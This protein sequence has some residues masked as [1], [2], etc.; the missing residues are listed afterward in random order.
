MGSMNRRTPTSRVSHLG[1]TLIELMVA[2]AIGAF[3]MIGAVTVFQ[4]SRTTFRVNDNVSRLQENARFALDTVVSDIRMAHYWGLTARSVNVTGRAK[5]TD[6]AGLGPAT[7]GQNWTINLESAVGATNNS[8]GWGC[9]GAAPVETNSDTLVVRR[10]SEES[11]LPAALTANTLYIQSNRQGGQI[12]AG[13]AIPATYTAAT[14][15]THRLIADGYYVSRTSSLSS[16]ANV[17][18]SLRRKTLIGGGTIQDQEIMT[19]IEDLQI[20][21]GVDTDLPGTANRGAVDRFVNAN[22]PILNPANAAYLPYAEVL[23]VRVWLRLRAE[24]TENGFVDTAA[25][26]YADQN[27]PAFNDGFRRIVVSKTI[28]IRNARPAT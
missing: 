5:P 14:S 12:F 6:P 11:L 2:L 20:E 22:D 3:L 17:V 28:Y 27:V 9:A 23:A 25:Y 16:G 7:C 4:H 10:A 18:P 1:M 24:R 19:G 8:Y 21:L 13:T 26:A 15:E